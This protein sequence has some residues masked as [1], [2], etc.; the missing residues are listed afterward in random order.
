MAF[1]RGGIDHLAVGLGVRLGSSQQVR[2]SRKSTGERHDAEGTRG[3]EDVV[4]GVDAMTKRPGETR[5]QTVRRAAGDRLGF[6]V[7]PADVAHNGSPIR[8]RQIEDQKKR[9][10]LATKYANDRVLLESLG[11]PRYNIA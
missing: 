5:E 7:K 4:S 8:N 9:E 6:I 3:P 1:G 11:A 2:A 10:Q